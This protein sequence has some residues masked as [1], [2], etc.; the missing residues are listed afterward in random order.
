[1]WSGVSGRGLTTR[2]EAARRACRRLPALIAAL[3]LA[4]RAVI[5]TDE[6]QVYNAEINRPGEVTLQ[7]HGNQ[8]VSGRTSAEFPGG[9]VPEGSFNGTPEFA[10]GVTDFW[11]VG[12][13]LPYAV[14]R[15]GDFEPGGAKIRTL[16]ATPSAHERRFFYG[17]NVEISNQ[18]LAFEGN[19]WNSEVRPIVGWRRRPIEFILNPIVD[20]ALS[21]PRRAI[22]FAPAARL[23]WIVSRVWAAGL[24]HYAGF[25]PIDRFDRSSRQ[26]QE[27]FAVADYSGRRLDLDFGIGRG[28]TSGS[29][30]WTVK[31]ILGWTLRD[32][33]RPRLRLD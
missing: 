12:L 27:L 4:T 24:E 3:S 10:L 13:Y 9:L 21:G 8:I 31:V 33:P 28:L 6:I 18:P 29:D 15:S 25:G 11:E 17:V 23:A 20:V 1:V 19:H 14:T 30:D 7:L 22:E 5:A 2:R 32:S 16:L 26:L